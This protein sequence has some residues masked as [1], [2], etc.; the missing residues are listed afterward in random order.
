M[1]SRLSYQPLQQVGVCCLT[2]TT[3]FTNDPKVR[4]NLPALDKVG[5]ENDE[6][7]YLMPTT[8]RGIAYMERM[9]GGKGAKKDAK[10]GLVQVNV[11]IRP[12]TR[13]DQQNTVQAVFN[14]GDFTVKCEQPGKESHIASYDQCFY[15]E[16]YEVC[17]HICCMIYS[18][19][20]VACG[21]QLLQRH[22]PFLC[23]SQTGV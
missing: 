15:G 11:R 21:R 18:G 5:V 3:A 17:S 12:F 6:D 9:G 8:E 16:Q 4:A 14:D 13:A 19:S 20:A 1:N 7:F 2:M 10:D 22:L 23:W